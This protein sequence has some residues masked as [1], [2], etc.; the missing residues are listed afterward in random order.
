MNRLFERASV[1]Q[2]ERLLHVGLSLLRLEFSHS[3]PRLCATPDTDTSLLLY[4]V[5]GVDLTLIL[6]CSYYDK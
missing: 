5:A 6:I 1:L 4:R 3:R 2:A